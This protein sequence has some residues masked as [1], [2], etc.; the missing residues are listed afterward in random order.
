MK[1]WITGLDEPWIFGVLS[2]DLS[3]FQRNHVQPRWQLSVVASDIQHQLIADLRCLLD[4]RVL[5]YVVMYRVIV[6]EW[7]KFWGM[8]NKSRVWRMHIFVYIIV[9]IITTK[10]V[11]EIT[12]MNCWKVC[13]HQCEKLFLVQYS[14]FGMQLNLV[15]SEMGAAYY[16]KYMRW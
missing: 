2:V 15:H 5:W 1:Q 7:W 4:T 14:M 13:F 6:S 12:P 3:K 10:L 11:N 8:V 16:F 9:I